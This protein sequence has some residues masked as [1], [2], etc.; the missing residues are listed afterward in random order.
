MGGSSLRNSQALR[1]PHKNPK[2]LPVEFQTHCVPDSL[3]HIAHQSWFI[4]GPA[5]EPMP[6]GL[7]DLPALMPQ[8][9]QCSSC[10][11]LP[12]IAATGKS[13][14]PTSSLCPPLTDAAQLPQAAH[15]PLQCPTFLTNPP[16]WNTPPSP[17]YATACNSSTTAGPCWSSQTA[18]AAGRCI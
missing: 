6:L 15:S 14:D 18:P 5:Y 12:S 17:A 3:G 13:C 2:S 16:G 4:Y 1:G 7:I 8:P 9:K 11:A 10:M